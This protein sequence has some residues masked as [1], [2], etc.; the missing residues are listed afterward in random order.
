MPR[1]A[2]KS[3]VMRM[4]TE[5]GDPRQMAPTGI[6]RFMTETTDLWINRLFTDRKGYIFTNNVPNGI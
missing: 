5:M 3:E 4:K 6:Y 2:Y 1:T